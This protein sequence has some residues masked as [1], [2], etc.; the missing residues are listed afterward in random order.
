MKS[1]SCP[2]LA[3]WAPWFTAASLSFALFSFWLW[4]S[5]WNNYLRYRPERWKCDR[6]ETVAGGQPWLGITTHTDTSSGIVLSPPSLALSRSLCDY[7]LLEMDCVSQWTVWALY[8]CDKKS[9]QEKGKLLAD[10]SLESWGVFSRE[11]LMFVFSTRLGRVLPQAVLHS[12]VGN[13]TC[14]FCIINDILYLF[15]IITSNLFISLST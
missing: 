6:W 9:F 10:Q 15:I 1:L 5:G 12:P 11:P 4:Q 14:V 7:E 13:C 3:V 2:S 8:H